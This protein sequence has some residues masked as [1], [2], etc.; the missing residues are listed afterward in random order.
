MRTIRMISGSVTDGSLQ[1]HSS[2]VHCCV[3]RWLHSSYTGPWQHL[4]YRPSSEGG[5]TSL[6]LSLSRLFGLYRKGMT[7]ECRG[8][9]EV[10]GAAS[11]QRSI[12]RWGDAAASRSDAICV[13]IFMN[14]RKAITSALNSRTLFSNC[15]WFI[16]LPYIARI[17]INKEWKSTCP[18]ECVR[19]DFSYFIRPHIDLLHIYLLL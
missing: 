11:W 17:V 18:E 12:L 8:V 14:H 19:C 5:R 9:R 6:S 16:L 1:K 15:S 10:R 7:I 4:L 2:T 3:A 13:W